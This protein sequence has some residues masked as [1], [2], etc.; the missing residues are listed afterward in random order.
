M[1]RL[2]NI[3]MG[4]WRGFM[5]AVVKIDIRKRLGKISRNIYGQFMEHLDD[6]IYPSVWD[7]ASPLSDGT[8]LRKDVIETLQQLSV[9]VVRWPGG[10][11]ADIYH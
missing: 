11:Y 1:K 8:G 6:C 4:G 7:D 2:V 3:D 9:P 10:C 5:K